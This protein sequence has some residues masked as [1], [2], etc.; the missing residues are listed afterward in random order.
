MQLFTLQYLANLKLQ[1]LIKDQIIEILKHS[2]TNSFD[3]K[4]EIKRK[5]KESNDKNE[6]NDSTPT[7]MNLQEWFMINQFFIISL[8]SMFEQD[9]GNKITSSNV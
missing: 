5:R 9:T 6:M 3:N 4:K 7:T 2:D 8:K 1:N